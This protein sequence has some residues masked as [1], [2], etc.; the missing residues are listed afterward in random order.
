MNANNVV[1][2]PFLGE[3]GW[4]L[5]SYI[6]FINNHHLTLNNKNHKTVYCFKGQ[7]FFFP[8]VNTFKYL[9]LINSDKLNGP[10]GFTFNKTNFLNDHKNDTIIYHNIKHFSNNKNFNIGSLPLIDIPFCDVFIGARNR[11]HCQFK[12]INWIPVINYF[13]NMNKQICI[14]GLKETTQYY[15]TDLIYS[16]E[17]GDNNSVISNFINNARYVLNVSSGMSILS[18]ILNK[19]QLLIKVPKNKKTKGRHDWFNMEKTFFVESLAYNDEKYLLDMVEQYSEK[20][21]ILLN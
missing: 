9:E 11:K 17:Y 21:N 8:N 2:F 6:P 4:F 16:Y 18:E 15:G 13:K 14:G 5:S 1:F 7:E 10:S 19:H 12:N 20:I 3:F